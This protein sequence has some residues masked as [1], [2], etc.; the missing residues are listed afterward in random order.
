MPDK[1]LFDGAMLQQEGIFARLRAGLATALE[2][3]SRGPLDVMP[4]DAPVHFD[5]VREQ[6]VLEGLTNELAYAL[7]E[8][9]RD[10][11]GFAKAAFTADVNDPQQLRTRRAAMALTVAIPL[12]AGAAF[13]GGVFLYRLWTIE[14][15]VTADD[16]VIDSKLFDI[17]SAADIPKT[18][19]KAAEK[20]GGG[21]GGGNKAPTPASKGK[22][23]TPSLA[24]PVLAPTTRPT[25]RPPA[26]P[27]MATVQVDPKMLPPNPDPNSFGD[28]KGVEGPPSDGPGSG[29]GIGSGSGGGVGSGNGTGVGP[30]NGYNM[31]GGDP[32]IGGRTGDD[33]ARPATSVQLLNQPRPNFTEAARLNKTQGAV[34]VKVLFGADGRVKQAKVVKG[35]PDGLNEMA[36]QA[37]YKFNFRPAMSSSGRPVDQWKTVNVA[38]TLR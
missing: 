4:G 26:L 35:L 15:V 6:N 19:P 31:G 38:F 27:T 14:A 25:P 33:D 16:Q 11:S 17:T 28:P 30:G 20:A 34:L 7:T 13:V 37:V 9:R 12:L 23:P 22:P 1:S 29:R 2:P 36:I 21:G 24:P 10:P 5:L 32:R 3:S 18:A 8:L